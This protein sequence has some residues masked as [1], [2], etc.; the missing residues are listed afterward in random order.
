[1]IGEEYMY[2]QN[3]VTD[4]ETLWFNLHLCTKQSLA[5]GTQ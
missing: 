4:F 1:M 2:V 5:S 3:N